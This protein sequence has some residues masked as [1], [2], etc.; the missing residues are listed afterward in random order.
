MARMEL[1]AGDVREVLLVV[2]RG[3]EGSPDR[4]G[5][6]AQLSL[7]GGMDPTWLDMFSEAARMAADADGPVDLLDARTELDGPDDGNDPDV[8]V[9]RVDPAWITDVARIPDGALDAL[10]GRWIDRLEEELGPLGSEEK[11]WIRELAQRIVAFCRSA[12]RAPAV[13]F[14]WSP[15]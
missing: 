11:P 8:I 10:T 14:V 2:G 13:I 12:D 6:H 9:E 5:V 3:M 15:R 4:S 7:G 1:V